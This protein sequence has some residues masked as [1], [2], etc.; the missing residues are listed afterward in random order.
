VRSGQAVGRQLASTAA[1]LIIL[2]DVSESRGVSR[3]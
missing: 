2:A 1:L 3:C